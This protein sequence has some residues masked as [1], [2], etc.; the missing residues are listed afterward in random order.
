MSKEFRFWSIEIDKER[1]EISGDDPE[2]KDEVI[3][4]LIERKKTF[5]V[6]DVASKS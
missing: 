5:K 3:R 4:E 6:F 2:R 1:R